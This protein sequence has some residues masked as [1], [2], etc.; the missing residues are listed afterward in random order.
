[1]YSKLR[2][3]WFGGW[4]GALAIVLFSGIVQVLTY[5]TWIPSNFTMV[6]GFLINV[7][8][9]IV[10]FAW[11]LWVVVNLGGDELDQK[12][13][14]IYWLCF[15]ALF[16]AAVIL[17]L[18]LVAY[19]GLTEIAY[20]V[21]LIAMYVA[22]IL[23]LLLII[24]LRYGKKTIKIVYIAFAVCYAGIYAITCCLIPS[25]A[26][27][28]PVVKEFRA[29]D[30]MLNVSG[31][32]KVKVVLVN[33]QSN[34]SG[35][36]RKEYL[37]QNAAPADYARYA[38]G[39]DNVFINYFNDNG[40]NTS[41]GAFVRAGLDCGYDIGFF[42]P[43]LGLADALSAQ[44]PGETIFIVKY[45]WGG[46]NLHTQWLSPSSDGETGELY[47]AFINFTRTNLDY[48]KSKGYDPEI[49]AMC[50][51]QGESDAFAQYCNQYYER[52]KNLVA[53]M[54][55]DLA[56]YASDDGIY[57][58]DAGISDSELWKEYQTINKAKQNYAATDDKAVFIDTIGA[59][60]DY[61]KEPSGEGVIP[62]TAHYDAMS[63]IKLGNLF[64]EQVI[65]AIEK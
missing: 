24:S 19:V 9:A 50:W 39:Y 48:L 52:T 56:D 55:R 51:M 45:A 5:F 65:A 15:G 28:V 11:L 10:T 17:P 26:G 22:M 12:H 21:G 16:G 59:G 20:Y 14:L 49:V 35:V 6:Y 53:D 43:E 25:P 29:M 58:V 13:F 23:S 47:E 64:A 44:Y 62:D 37:Q 46:S 31:T 27:L 18:D 8:I 36:S 42:G 33:G 54:R 57:F 2:N 4:L 41:G 61:H 40:N 7:A 60:L 63:G 30:T 38:A 3:S 34:A 1:M 32:P